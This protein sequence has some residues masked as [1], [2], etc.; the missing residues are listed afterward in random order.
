MKIKENININLPNSDANELNILKDKKTRLQEIRQ[1]K[2]E[3][4]ILRSKCKYEDMS[5]KTIKYF[6]SLESRN[7]TSKLITKLTNS[8]GENYTNTN[9][10]LHHQNKYYQHLYSESFEIDEKPLTEIIGENSNKLTNDE[11]INLITLLPSLI[12]RRWVGR[13]TQ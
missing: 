11:S 12:A 1:K 9:Y 3:G 5:E 2:L 10:I 8:D 4:V 7:F 13:Q 6:L